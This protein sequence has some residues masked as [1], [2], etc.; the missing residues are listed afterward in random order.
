MKNYYII[1]F[2]CLFFGI[3]LALISKTYLHKKVCDYLMC[4]DQYMF[5]SIY[6]ES[7][8]AN[9]RIEWDKD[10]IWYNFSLV[11]WINIITTYLGPTTKRIIED[12]A[13]SLSTVGFICTRQVYDYTMIRRSNNCLD[14]SFTNQYSIHDNKKWC[15]VADYRN[16]NWSNIYYSLHN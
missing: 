10:T 3:L 12:C 1:I 8:I 14:L 16:T 7:G 6:K 15:V 4:D 13:V 11:S 5:A 2:L 9:I